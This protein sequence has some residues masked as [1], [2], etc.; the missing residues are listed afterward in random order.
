MGLELQTNDSRLWKGLRKSDDVKAML[1]AIDALPFYIGAKPFGDDETPIVMIANFIWKRFSNVTP[2]EVVDAF[3]LAAS[4][5]LML[6]GKRVNANTYGGVLDIE[7]VGRVLK[8]YQLRQRS[9]AARPKL[10][11]ENKLLEAPKVDMSWHWEQILEDAKETGEAPV[12][13]QYFLAYEYLVSQGIMKPVQEPEGRRAKEAFDI[14]AV[15][16][17]RIVEYLKHQNIIK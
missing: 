11:R 5:D 6:D 16:K 9:E 2:I 13:R 17:A 4:G 10:V 8:A 14:R 1:K 15:K 3:E 12:L 7:F